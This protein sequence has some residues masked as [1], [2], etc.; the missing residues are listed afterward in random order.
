MAAA[1]VLQDSAVKP[2][3]YEPEDLTDQVVA[4]T[5]ILVGISVPEA[6]IAK[7]SDM[8]KLMAYDW[9]MREYL[10]ASDNHVRR[11]A[12]PYLVTLCEWQRA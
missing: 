11:R 5:L 6:N 2:Q 1:Q 12:K 3:F 10:N 4:D 9:A 8:E 7:W